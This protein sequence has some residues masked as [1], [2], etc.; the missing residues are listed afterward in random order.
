MSRAKPSIAEMHDRERAE[1]RGKEA[2]RNLRLIEEHR[3]GAIDRYLA[4][5]EAL[6]YEGPQMLLGAG[7]RR[8]DCAHYR[9]CLDRFVAAY[10]QRGDADAHC[11]PTCAGFRPADPVEVVM[12]SS[13]GV[14]HGGV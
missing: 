8:D 13:L 4:K 11:S 1:W 9:A 3:A 7:D 5:R 2:K 12:V 6:A 14:I 10:C